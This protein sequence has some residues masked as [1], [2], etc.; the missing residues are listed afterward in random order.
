MSF[1]HFCLAMDHSRSEGAARLV[2]FAL[3]RSADEATGSVTLSVPEIHRRTRV[4]RRGIQYALRDLEALGE[5]LIESRA[6]LHQ[7]SLENRY[8]VCVCP[9]ADAV[10]RP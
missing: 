5:L 2:L 7:G 1:L 6:T 3:A 8:T 4:S 10:G 9:R